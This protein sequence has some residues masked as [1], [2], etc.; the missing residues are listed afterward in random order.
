MP[1]PAA[2]PGGEPENVP[3]TMR[4]AALLFLGHPTPAIIIAGLLVLSFFRIQLPWQPADALVAAC[5]ACFWLG[6][7]WVVHRAL[8]H[9]SFGWPGR[10]V[11]EGHHHAPYYHVSI[12]SPAIILPAMAL[13]GGALWAALGGSGLALTG[14][15]T[16]WTMGLAYEWTHFLVHTK[17][18]PGSALGRRVRRHHMLHHCRSEEFWFSFLVPGVDG[19]LGTAPDPG[20]VPRSALARKGA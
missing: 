3:T 6:Q 1:R 15:S 19:L 17:V 14:A 2:V 12:D 7:E 8:L 10:D 18:V 11:H 9:S 5:V 13:S 20:A 16:F 4:E